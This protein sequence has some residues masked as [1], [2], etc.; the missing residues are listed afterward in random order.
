MTRLKCGKHACANEILF[1][2][3]PLICLQSERRTSYYNLR[4]KPLCK[5]YYWFKLILNLVNHYYIMKHCSVLWFQRRRVKCEKLT[6]DAYPWQKFTWPMARWAKNQK[7]FWFL[8]C[9]IKKNCKN[10][11]EIVQYTMFH[12]IIMINQIQY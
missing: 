5:L 4:Q 12:N 2:N 6:D 11:Q 1:L 7:H 10:K 8:I 3:K 9:K